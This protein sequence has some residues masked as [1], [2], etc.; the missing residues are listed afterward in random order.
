MFVLPRRAIHLRIQDALARFTRTSKR[1]N[2]TVVVADVAPT[3][4]QQPPA[5]VRF[6]WPIII[7]N[8]LLMGSAVEITW[9]H[10]ATLVKDLE[11]VAEKNKK[12]A[13][14][15]SGAANPSPSPDAK[16]QDANAVTAST[17]D[18][19]LRWERRP[20]WQRAAFCGIYVMGWAISTA[21][22]L[23]YR[24]TYVTKIKFF[25][26]PRIPSVSANSASAPGPTTASKPGK[27]MI[28]IYTPSA[29]S[30]LTLPLSELTIQDG[31]NE[32]ELVIRARDI[33]D[34][35]GKVKKRR[36][37]Y[38]F[39]S[40]TDALVDGARYASVESARYASVESA[41]DRVLFAWDGVG[42][43]SNGTGGTGKVKT[44]GRWKSGP[45]VRD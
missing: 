14:S 28:Q 5:W 26:A 18:E 38:W 15:T 41:R 44:T 29:H 8:A 3:F 4:I 40:L 7:A 16:Y 35:A 17:K 10:W 25:R 9:T 12:I 2:S 37:E 13:A 34:E 24:Q 32:T 21:W 45:V 39:V 1:F 33:L 42:P 6:A 31:R 22:L 11:A 27:R 23:K 43:G 19:A 20:T 30:G 36:R